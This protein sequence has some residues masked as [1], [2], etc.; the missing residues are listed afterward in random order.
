MCTRQLCIVKI[1][2]EVVIIVLKII[3]LQ[4][5]SRAQTK[6]KTVTGVCVSFRRSNKLIQRGQIF[7]E[8]IYLLKIIFLEDKSTVLYT[9]KNQKFVRERE[10]CSADKEVLKLYTYGVYRFQIHVI[11]AVIYLH[12]MQR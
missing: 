8:T 4:K 2:K 3:T 9:R 11:H 1:N 5:Q 10:N 7:I 12:C 6:R